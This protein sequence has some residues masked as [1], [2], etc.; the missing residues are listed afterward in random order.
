MKK[1]KSAKKGLFLSLAVILIISALSNMLYAYSGGITGRTLKSGTTGCSSCHTQGTQVNGTLTGPDTVTAGQTVAY[2]LNISHTNSGLMGCDIAI[3][4]GVLAVGGASSYLRAA[5]GELT[6]INGISGSSIQF[7][8][9]Y[10]APGSDGWD[11]LYVTVTAAHAGNWRFLANKHI[12]VKLATGITNQNIPVNFKL[13]QNYPNPFNP[14]TKIGFS[15]GSAG[16]VKLTVYDLTGNEVAILMNGKKDAGNYDIEFK[17][18]N[19]SSGVYFYKLETN[20]FTD[21]KRMTLIK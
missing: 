21:V 15:I 5:S 20:E 2:T 6:H 19:L 11:T 7:S 10:T 14:T 3:Q 9:N 17:A 13:N 12:Y 8:F 1:L 16:Y 18:E 4:R